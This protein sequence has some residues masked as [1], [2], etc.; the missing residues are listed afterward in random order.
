MT[1][2]EAIEWAGGRVID[3]AAKLGI[4]HGAISQWDTVPLKQQYRLAAISKGKL[5]VDEDES[6]F[7]QKGFAKTSWTP[8]DL[9][10]L[11]SRP[12]LGQA[13]IEEVRVAL[14]YVANLVES[15]DAA[16]ADNR[17]L[18]DEREDVVRAIERINGIYE[19][20]KRSGIVTGDRKRV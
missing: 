7:V 2:E 12:Q 9:R 14:L 15:A 11:A 13:D 5:T 10:S 4:T 8:K 3:L 16:V 19:D 1:K 6:A 20:L 18:L 17:R